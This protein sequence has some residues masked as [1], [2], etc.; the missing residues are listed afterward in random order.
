VGG[1][2]LWAARTHKNSSN[3][4]LPI[5]NELPEEPELH[6]RRRVVCRTRSRDEIDQLLEV[7]VHPSNPGYNLPRIG[8]H[9]SPPWGLGR[10]AKSLQVS[11]RRAGAPT[12]FS[13]ARSGRRTDVGHTRQHVVLRVGDGDR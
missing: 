11:P 4:F 6:L 5:A 2:G 3:S 10:S 8:C 9:G 7:L 12:L 1:A 13:R